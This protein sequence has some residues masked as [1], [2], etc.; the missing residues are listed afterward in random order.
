M[1][2]PIPDDVK[3]TLG[4]LAAPQQVLLRKYIATLRADIT[5]LEAEVLGKLRTDC[6]TCIG[7]GSFRDE[8]LDELL[9]LKINSFSQSLHFVSFFLF[10]F[11]GM[12]DPDSHA[13]YH[14]HDR[15]TAGTYLDVCRCMW[16]WCQT[17]SVWKEGEK[18]RTC[19]L[20]NLTIFLYIHLLKNNT[21]HRS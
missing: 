9:V 17:D 12:K 4:Q 21:N 1:V 15:C 18:A 13:H 3:A 19:L 6:T 11:V 8:A 7:I 5:E 20:C 14:G 2:K 16:K 10:L